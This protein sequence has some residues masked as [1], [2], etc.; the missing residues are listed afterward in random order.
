MGMDDDDAIERGPAAARSDRSA[1]R[2]GR[3]RHHAPR[4]RSA[5]SN[6][7]ENAKPP[8]GNCPSPNWR[9]VSR[10]VASL[11][12]HLGVAAGPPR[13]VPT[14]RLRCKLP[15]IP[16]EAAAQRPRR[17]DRHAAHERSVPHSAASRKTPWS[18]PVILA[19]LKAVLRAAPGAL[20]QPLA[21]R[22]VAGDQPDRIRER[23][24]AARR[25]QQAIVQMRHHIAP[26][27]RPRS[28]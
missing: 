9:A 27:R 13:G 12:H 23:F 28:R 21:Q 20:A 22:R 17:S 24:G 11:T 19:Q 14:R 15:A 3:A 25:N 26:S 7:Q 6:P 10:R 18:S 16:A 1:G 2:Q 5:I 8:A 4:R